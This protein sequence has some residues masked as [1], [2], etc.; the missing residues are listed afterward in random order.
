VAPP[1]R[2]LVVPPV[3]PVA[4]PRGPAGGAAPWFSCP[5]APSSHR[6]TVPPVAPPRG[7]AVP[8]PRR[9]TVPPSRRWRRPVV[10]LSCGPVV[11]PS[12]RP[13]GGAAP[14]SSCPA[15]RVCVRMY[16]SGRGAPQ[17]RR[18]CVPRYTFG[19]AA[20]PAAHFEA[21]ERQNPAAVP[22]VRA[23]ARPIP[24]RE[25]PERRATVPTCTRQRTPEAKAAVRAA[26]C[27]CERTPGRRGIQNGHPGGVQAATP[28]PA[29]PRRRAPAPPRRRT[30]PPG[31][32]G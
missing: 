26:T 23:A 14:W 24:L 17:R 21:P 19:C 7:P 25:G 8:R 1:A 32:R 13:A 16:T 15:A 18:M 27:I 3:A 4:P 20:S 9:P 12:H 2:R 28:A 30:A 11:P 5:A 6:P 29:P 31:R 10:Q 22:T